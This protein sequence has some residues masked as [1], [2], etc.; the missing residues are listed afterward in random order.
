MSYR[1]VKL[2]RKYELRLA[3]RVSVAVGPA[4]AGGEVEPKGM[5]ARLADVAALAFHHVERHR[6]VIVDPLVEARGQ[7]AA[8]A[9][10]RRAKPSDLPAA[11]L[12]EQSCFSAHSISQRQLRYLHASPNAVFV[13]AE[14]QGRVVGEGIALV[15]RNRTSPSGRIYSLAVDDGCRRERIGER[16]LQA[17]LED[18]TRRG[19][20]RVSLEVEQTNASAVRLYERNGFREVDRLPAYYGDGRAGIRMVRELVDVRL[21]EAPACPD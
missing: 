8:T 14:K 12:L 19:V 10:V 16:L 3:P 7:A 15:R 17:M 5:E 20:R 2:L 11:A 18:L 4:P 1:P 9:V 13:V 21:I 6:R